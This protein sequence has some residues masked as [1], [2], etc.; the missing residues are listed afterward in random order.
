ML[1][2]KEM[3]IN[4]IGNDLNES[5]AKENTIIKSAFIHVI[6]SPVIHIWEVSNLNL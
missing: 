5:F 1:Q 2:I 4:A 3:T 6:V